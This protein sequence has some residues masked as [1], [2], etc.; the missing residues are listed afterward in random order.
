[1]VSKVSLEDP[2]THLR[3]ERERC[4]SEREIYEARLFDLIETVVVI[5]QTILNYDK[6]IEKLEEDQME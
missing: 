5:N 6:A 2:L 3:R 1:M 4:L